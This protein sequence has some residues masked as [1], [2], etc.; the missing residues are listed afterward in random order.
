[1]KKKF[2]LVLNFQK[3][4]QY[5]SRKKQNNLN[6]VKACQKDDIFF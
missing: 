4:Q 6:I 1:M 3:T 5:Y 2:D